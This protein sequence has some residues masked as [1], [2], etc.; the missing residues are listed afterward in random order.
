MFSVT[1]ENHHFQSFRST[2]LAFSTSAN[3]AASIGSSSYTPVCGGMLITA[4][5]PPWKWKYDPLIYQVKFSIVLPFLREW[6][7][8]EQWHSPWGFHSSCSFH[9][10]KCPLPPTSLPLQTNQTTTLL[11]SGTSEIQLFIPSSPSLILSDLTM[12]GFLPLCGFVLFSCQSRGTQ[13]PWP[14]TTRKT[15][16][17]EQV[18]PIMLCHERWN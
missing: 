4:H 17:T 14:Y 10:L 9:S 18:R 1:N 13:C 7:L 15:P 2:L 6:S 12:A 16:V 3:H 5:L 8:I 11:S